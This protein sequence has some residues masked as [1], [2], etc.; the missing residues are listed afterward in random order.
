MR[1]RRII[2]SSVACLSVPQFPYYLIKGMIFGP[3]KKVI[4]HRVCVFGVIIL[5]ETF[6]SLRITERDIII[7]VHR[8]TYKVSVILVRF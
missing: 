1:M 5:S 7:I 6:L 2:L 4:Q 8:S 3:P